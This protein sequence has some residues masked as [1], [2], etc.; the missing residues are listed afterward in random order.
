ML[1]TPRS[2]C[3]HARYLKLCPKHPSWTRLAR[4]SPS[5]S[6]PHTPTVAW[7]E[8]QLF[9]DFSLPLTAQPHHSNPH[10]ALLSHLDPSSHFSQ[11]PLS[12]P[13]LSHHHLSPKLTK[14]PRE[15]SPVSTPDL[16]PSCCHSLLKALHLVFTALRCQ[17]QTSSVVLC[18]LVL[19]P[20]SYISNNSF[21]PLPGS[22]HISFLLASRT[23][24][25]LSCP[26][27]LA[28]AGS[29]IRNC[30]PIPALLRQA[31]SLPSGLVYKS[32]PPPDSLSICLFF[33]LLAVV[34]TSVY[35]NVYPTS[36]S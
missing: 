29:S 8:I 16:N 30:S 10:P 20:L 7:P 35:S 17:I 6:P 14:R 2:L 3:E 21:P 15:W 1:L 5:L 34:C 26:G 23:N 32:L 28:Q 12:A 18:D 4:S 11:P 33:L 9:C 36:V 31:P 13:Y 24:Q 27:G 19:P 22:N 25:A